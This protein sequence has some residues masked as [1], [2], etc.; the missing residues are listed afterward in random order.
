M[1]FAYLPK[2]N[3]DGMIK[4]KE[5][6]WISEYKSLLWLAEPQVPDVEIRRTYP[7]LN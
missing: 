1:D 2:G 6:L 4:K 7:Q 3:K 5:S